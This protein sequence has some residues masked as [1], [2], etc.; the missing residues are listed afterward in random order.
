MF[1]CKENV[2][3]QLKYDGHTADDVKEDLKLIY[4]V[5]Y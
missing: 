3:S 4:W 1:D 2:V 5:D